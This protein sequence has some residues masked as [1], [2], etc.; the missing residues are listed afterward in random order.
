ME[1]MESD[2]RAKARCV[3]EIL[4]GFYGQPL[5]KEQRDPLSELILTILSQNTADINTE[6]A[7]SVL[8]ERF[9]TWGDVMQAD[10]DSVA[11]AI[12]IAGLSRIKA[13]RI[14]RI[15]QQLYAER[16]ALDMSFL[17]KMPLDEARAYLMS[18]HGVGP[19]TTACVLLFSLQRPVLPVDTHVH[20]VSR[21]LGLIPQKASAEQA[22]GLLEELI[23]PETYYAFHL[24][25]IRHGR[26]ICRAQTPR[27]V[28]C[29]LRDLCD[30]YQTVVMPT[31][32]ESIDAAQEPTDC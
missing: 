26:E 8:R 20:R 30:Y 7:Y 27:C 24:N 28:L 23:P 2:L 29:P 15:L 22:H 17:G 13:P 1:S 3:H 6:R 19:K 14:Q 18:L 5:P 10:V 9:P 21:R 32:K 16:G 12:R 25:V 4:L 31:H 11:D